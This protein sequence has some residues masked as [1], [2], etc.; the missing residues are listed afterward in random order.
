MT[1]LQNRSWIEIDLNA[2]THNI[3]TIQRLLKHDDAFMAV[4]KADAYGHGAVRIAKHCQNMGIHAFAVATIDEAIEL[5]RHQIYGDILILGYTDPSRC[6]ELSQYRLIQTVVN[7]DHAQ[8]LQQKGYPIAV[9]VKIDTGMH[10]LG[11][12]K[13]HL[14]EIERLYELDHLNVQGYFTHLCVCDSGRKED[15]KFTYQ[16][17]EDF[18][19]C[20]NYIKQ[21][22]EVGEIHIQS[23]YGLINYPEIQCDY[24]RVGIAM[25]GVQS[26]YDCYVKQDLH[27]QPVLSLKSKVAMIHRVLKGESIGYGKTFKTKQD[28]LIAVIPIGYADGLPRSLS[29]KGHVLIHGQKCPIVGRICMDQMMVDVTH[30]QDIQEHDIVTI[31]GCDGDHE[32]KVE[33]IASLTDTISNEI[34]SRLGT[35]LRKI[36][37]GGHHVKKKKI[38]KYLQDSKEVSL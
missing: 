6:F 38:S 24:A 28:S 25:Y 14:D 15:Q 35:R 2:L 37:I 22:H 34:L 1:I 5:R 7:L 4:V 17:I 21:K 16:Q 18:Y 33:M 19:A 32:I 13:N 12:D 3:Q 31:I 11:F 20:I 26:S 36:Y 30:I 27:L 23:S 9:H 8:E 29:G 10:R